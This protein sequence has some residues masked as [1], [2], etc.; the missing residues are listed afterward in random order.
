MTAQDL[1]ITSIPFCAEK[2]WCGGKL[3]TRHEA[4]IDPVDRG[5]TLGLGVFETLLFKDA[6]V[7]AFHRHYERLEHSARQ[8]A[9]EAPERN[10]LRAICA[11]VLT[12]NSLDK[13]LARIRVSLSAGPYA[14]GASLTPSAAT[15]VVTASALPA[16]ASNT[17][18]RLATVPWPRNEF[19]ALVGIKALSYAENALALDYARR[20]SADEALILNTQGQLCEGSTSNLWYFVGDELH[21]PAVESGCLPGITR[22]LLV[23]YCGILGVSVNTQPAK[24]EALLAASEVFITSATRG[25]QGVSSVDGVSFAHAPGRQ[26]TLL[27]RGFSE[28]LDGLS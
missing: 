5:F 28:Y 3:C 27:Q 18:A 25:I 21:T 11:T 13:G 17:T 4:S 20:H 6:K 26:T 1:S 15:L 14:M 19:G 10:T 9:I 24:L 7:P 22:A 23:E 8:L 2:I 16:I 12:A